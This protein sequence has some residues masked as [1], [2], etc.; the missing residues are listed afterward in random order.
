MQLKWALLLIVAVVVASL[1]EIVPAFLIKSNVPTIAGIKP[2][3]PLELH[4]R[5]IYIREGCYT[6]HSHSIIS[7]HLGS[8]QMGIL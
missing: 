5:D 2:Y 6:C 3:T 4:G 1:F 8:W 7:P